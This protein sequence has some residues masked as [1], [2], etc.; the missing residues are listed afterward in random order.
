MKPLLYK[1]YEKFLTLYSA[2]PGAK[3]ARRNRVHEQQGHKQP[4]LVY[5]NGRV[6]SSRIG[7]TC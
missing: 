4:D 5:L 6:I 2:T 3:Y 1:V 7:C